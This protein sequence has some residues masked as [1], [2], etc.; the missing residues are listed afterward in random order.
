LLTCTASFFF[1]HILPEWSSLH[2]HVLN[3]R[4]AAIDFVIWKNSVYID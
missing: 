3:A 2:D 4:T 1:H